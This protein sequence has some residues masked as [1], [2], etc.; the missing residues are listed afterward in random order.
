VGV[1]ELLR[2]AQKDYKFFF[3]VDPAESVFLFGKGRVKSRSK[4]KQDKEAVNRDPRR[5]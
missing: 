5:G 4:S 3:K 2:S 1:Q